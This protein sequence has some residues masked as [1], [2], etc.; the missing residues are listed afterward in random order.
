MCYL[1]IYISTYKQVCNDPEFEMNRTDYGRETSS[2]HP[3]VTWQ[4][5]RTLGHSTGVQE[6]CQTDQI[7][8]SD[9][10]VG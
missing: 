9:V 6:V 4:L 7:I 5:A 3:G 10:A 2:Q 8:A 1:H